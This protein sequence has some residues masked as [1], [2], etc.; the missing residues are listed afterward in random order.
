MSTL[1]PM[2]S[3]ETAAAQLREAL[4]HLPA[5]VAEPDLYDPALLRAAAED[6]S[7]RA[8]V[9]LL[10]EAA[11]CVRWANLAT[12]RATQT[13]GELRAAGFSLTERRAIDPLRERLAAA[14]NHTHRGALILDDADRVTRVSLGLI[15]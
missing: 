5:L 12:L 14:L 7:L 9:R 13:P 3:A 2:R 6:G 11:D 15:A 1:I 10:A 8:V 4:H